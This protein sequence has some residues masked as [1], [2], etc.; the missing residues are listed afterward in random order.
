MLILGIIVLGMAIGWV[1]N[2]ILG[3][4]SRPKNWAELLMAG[5]AWARS[6]AGS[7]REPDR[8]RRSR[9]APERRSSG[10]SSEPCIVLAR[11]AR[12]QAAAGSSRP[13]RSDLL[14]GALR[15]RAGGDPRRR[16]LARP[17]VRRGRRHAAV[18]RPRR[19][20]VP[21]RRRREPLRRLR[22][23]LG[24]AALRTRPRRDR[25]GRRARPPPAARRSARRPSSRSSSPSASSTPCRASRW[26]GS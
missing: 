19:G 14:G 26:S 12:D 21:G 15:A 25:R 1:A 17:R 7:A 5:T 16:R 9:P 10:R 23:V 20:R 13:R 24:R 3:G 6:W 8:R 2:M 4:G 11:V 18:H 22:A